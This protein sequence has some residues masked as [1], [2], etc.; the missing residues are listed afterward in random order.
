MVIKY[1]SWIIAV[2]QSY[3][4]QHAAWDACSNIAYRNICI[5]VI[6]EL[7]DFSNVLQRMFDIVLG[8]L[9]GIVPTQVTQYYIKHSLYKHKTYPL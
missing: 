9:C 5:N 4:Q 7:N 2:V 8:H 6:A 3:G 1:K